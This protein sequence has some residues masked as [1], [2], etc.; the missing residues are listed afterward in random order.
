[1]E[2]NENMNQ[3]YN[4]TLGLYFKNASLYKKLSDLIFIIAIGIS[5][6]TLISTYIVR[7]N[8]LPGVCP[9]ESKTELYYLSIG[10]LVI[11]IFISF[12]DKKKNK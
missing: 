11:A 6:Y 1:M 4:K 8:L 3:L 10:L 12:F 2:V 9:I 7:S 5:L